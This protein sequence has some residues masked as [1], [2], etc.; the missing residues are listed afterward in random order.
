MHRLEINIVRLRRLF[1]LGIFG[2]LFVLY[3]SCHLQPPSHLR[4]VRNFVPVT[5]TIVTT[6]TTTGQTTTLADIDGNYIVWTF[7]LHAVTGSYLIQLKASS[8]SR[9]LKL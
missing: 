6:V 5:T 7:K 9:A 2:N 3:T 4:I 8:I 1:K